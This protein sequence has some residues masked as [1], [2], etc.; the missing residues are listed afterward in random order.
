MAKINQAEQKWHIRKL[1]LISHISFFAVFVLTWFCLSFEVDTHL[2]I[3][4]TESIV[5]YRPRM[6]LS[7]ILTMGLSILALVFYFHYFFRRDRRFKFTRVILLLI[8][9]LPLLAGLGEYALVQY[10]L[11]TNNYENCTY[12]GRSE[13][14]REPFYETLLDRQIWALRGDC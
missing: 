4:A 12:L 13:E 2:A 11:N 7:S 1:P 8:F 3:F 5:E 9:V 14:Y 6:T 10:R